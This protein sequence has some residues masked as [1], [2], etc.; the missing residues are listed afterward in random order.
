MRGSNGMG[1]F[2]DKTKKTIRG[3]SKEFM[4]LVVLLLIVFIL[5]VLTKGKFTS[6]ANLQS[7]AAQLPEFGFFTLGM[8]ICILTGGINL[9]V[10]NTG[11]MASIVGAMA[12]VKI[13]AAGEGSIGLAIFAGILCVFVV[14]TLGGLLNGFAISIIGVTPILATLAT[15]MLYEGI[16]LLLSNGYAISGFPKAF[17]WIGAGKVFGIPFPMILFIFAI[18][19]YVVL[20]EN[21][22]WGKR[23]YMIGCNPKATRFSGVNNKKV[24]MRIYLISALCG[25]FAAL[26]IMSRYNSAK[27]D[28]GS[29]YLM[30][31]VTASV[32]GGTDI[33]GGYGRVLG[34]MVAIMI[35]QSISSG[36]NL[37]NV[38]RFLTDVFMGVLLLLVLIL[39]FFS[40]V[41]KNARNKKK[42]AVQV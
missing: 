23:V 26:L 22:P 38:N 14:A 16:G 5:S 24:L 31:A 30:K 6:A 2:M 33:N 11:A 28:Y 18:I 29:S 9:S 27:V 34:T 42:T 1:K 39:N 36:L 37:L 32:L 35:I 7:M 41:I 20:L 10:V 25:G 21:T 4:L 15:M 8:M 40:A 12:M 13:Y 3:S 17:T 19:A